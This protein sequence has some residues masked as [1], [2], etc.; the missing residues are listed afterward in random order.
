MTRQCQQTPN[1]FFRFSFQNRDTELVT[2]LQRQNVQITYRTDDSQRGGLEI[3][4]RAG[5]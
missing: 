3:Q 5:D 2:V 1:R 4:Q